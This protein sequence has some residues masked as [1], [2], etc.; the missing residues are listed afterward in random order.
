MYC[1]FYETSVAATSSSY[2]WMHPFVVWREPVLQTFI[3]VYCPV[4]QSQFCSF[5]FASIVLCAQN[6]VLQPYMCAQQNKRVTAKFCLTLELN[7][8]WLLWAIWFQFKVLQFPLCIT[9]TFLSS[10]FYT[11]LA[12]RLKFLQGGKWSNA[13]FVNV[14]H[15]PNWAINNIFWISALKAQ[16]YV[17]L[18]FQF[19][20][21]HSSLVLFR[22]SSLGCLNCLHLSMLVSLFLRFPSIMLITSCF[23]HGFLAVYSLLPTTWNPT[24]CCFKLVPPSV[25]VF[26]KTNLFCWEHCTNKALFI[27]FVKN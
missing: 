8:F 4:L 26:V 5:L 18:I 11:Q 6:Y 22:S 10:C 20:S 27:L 7:I 2:F 1:I 25:E 3:S 16:I 15:V 14:W 21:I 13:K 19:S 9:I 12:F 17:N 24:Q 23:I